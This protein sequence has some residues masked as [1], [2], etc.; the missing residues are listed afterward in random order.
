[1]LR[2]QGIATRIVNG[3]QTGQY[4][5]QAKRY[6]V[7]QKD[8]HSWVEVYFPKQNVWVPFDPTPAAGDEDNAASAGILG[9]FTTYMEALETMWV[10]Y[11]VAY[12]NQGQR[13]MARSFRQSF[14]A[15][16]FQFTAWLNTVQ[17]DLTKSYDDL[18]EQER[19]S[20]GLVPFYLYITAAAALLSAFLIALFFIIRRLRSSL[21]WRDLF[22]RFKKAEEAKMV[23]FYAR[24]IAALRDK[25]FVRQPHQTPVEFA[26]LL[27]MPEAKSLTRIYNAVRFGNK[28]LTGEDRTA[29]ENW[30]TKL[31]A[32]D[33]TASAS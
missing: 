32:R 29:I 21:A 27:A 24:M 13:S 20:G 7:R 14:S 28:T 11:V 6:I 23:E 26:E 4:N 5:D 30:L 16:M 25:G 33:R 12:D 31:E 19:S 1:M 18:Q 22:A 3:F 2:T 8:A 9:A 10:E 17:H 15:Q